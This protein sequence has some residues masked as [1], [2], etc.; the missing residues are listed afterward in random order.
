[1]PFSAFDPVDEE[2][3][4]TE[5]AENAKTV[6]TLSK[7]LTQDVATRAM[8][9]YRKAPYIPAS[10]ILSMAKAGTSDQAVDAVLPSAARKMVADLDP[11]KEPK[12]SWFERNVSGKFKTASRWTF[13][14][15]Q[16][17]PDLAQNVASQA[18][19]PNDPAGFDGWFKS[20][21]LGTMIGDSEQAGS[22]FF[23]GGEAL[24]KQA[25]RARRVRGTING[26]AWTVGRGAAQLAF[27]PGS[28]PYNVLSGFVDAAVAIG[29][30]PTAVLGKPVAA[31]R[32]GKAV[33][34]GVS[35]AAEVAAFA[36]MAVR[37]EAGLEAAEQMAFNASK[38]GTW[39]RTDK[40]AV[41]LTK[42][43]ADLAAD[44]TKTVDDKV[45]DVLEKFNYSI[46][47][48]IARR[49]A[50]ADDITKVE[51]LLG[52]AS[53]RLTNSVDEVLLPKDVRDIR[54][55]TWLEDKTERVP[56]FRSVRNNR[57]F[58]TMPK[59]TV[60]INGSGLDKAQAIRNYS[61]YLKGVGIAAGSDEYTNV[62]R[63][64]VNAY[65][66]S[67][68]GAARPAVQ[69]AFDEAFKVT[70]GKATTKLTGRNKDMV[71]QRI[72]DA[73]DAEL[74][75]V[76]S[77]TGDEIGWLDDGGFIQQ[78][79]EV[80]PQEVLDQFPPDAW[81]RL[82]H[83]GPGALNEMADEVAVLPDFRQ[84]RRY[85]GM[86]NRVTGNAPTEK[87]LQAVEAVQQEFWKP[88]T[89]ATGGYIMRNMIDA[90]TRIAMN[91]LSNAFTHPMD[92]IMWSMNKK[93]FGDIRGDKFDKVLLFSKNNF[94]EQQKEYVEALQEGIYRHL[95]DPYN[96]K[97][98]AYR[99]GNWA[100]VNRSKDAR[101]HTIGYVDNLAQLH[102]DVINGQIARFQLMG[103][104]Q[105]KITDYIVTWLN[106]PENAKV[107][108]SLERFAR[109]G[110]KVKD[111]EADNIATFALSDG[112]MNQFVTAW[113]HRLSQFKVNT[114]TKGDQ[115]LTFVVAHNR[116]PLMTTDDAGRKVVAPLERIREGDI[117]SYELLSGNGAA[118]SLV[119]LGGGQ[120]GVVVNRVDAD[121]RT[122][123][124]FT[125]EPSTEATLVVQPVAVDDAGRPLAAIDIPVMR[126]DPKYLGSSF[127]HPQLRDLIDM[128]G[129]EGK[130]AMV[131]KAAQRGQADDKVFSKLQEAR[132][133]F[134]DKFFGGLYGTL[135]QK[136]EKSPVFRQ[137]YYREIADLAD[138]LA[139]AEAQKILTNIRRAA[140][141]DEVDMTR[142]VGSKDIIKKLQDV[143]SSTSDAVGTA[144][145]LDIYAKAVSLRQTKD[146]LYNASER[147]NLEDML[148]VVI[149][150]G[151]A[152]R[153]V[154]GTYASALLEDPSRIRRAQL[155]FDGGRK[156]DPD[157][158]GQGFFYKDPVSG[159]YSF[160]FPLSGEISKLLTGIEAPMQAP[161][162]RLSIGLGLYPS[163]GPVGQ[164]AANRIIPDTPATDWI[165]RILF[166]YGRDQ[167]IS[168][169]PKWAQRMNEAVE[170]NT[171]NLQNVYGNT[172][173]ET[174]RALSA[175][176]EYDLS[177]PDEQEKLYADARQKAR[178]LTGLRALGQFFGPT[179]PSPEFKIETEAGDM[180]GSQ[181]VKEFQ[182]LQAENYDTA[183]QR[184]LEIYGNDALLYLSNKTESVAGGLEA[185]EQ[186][187]DWERNNE[188]LLKK[189]PAVAGFM[190]PGGDNFSFEVWSRQVREGKRRR[191][192]DREI[193]ALA[194]YRAASA[195][196][197]ELRNKLPVNPS[198][199]QKAWLKKWRVQLNKEYPGFPVVAEFNPGEFPAQIEQMKRMVNEGSLADNE[200]AGALKTYLQKRDE[201]LASL[202]SEG[203]TTLASNAA[204]PV[205]DWLGSIGRA[206]V[207]EV[208]E[209]GRI[210]DRL[211]S[212]EVEE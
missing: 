116:I 139:P 32:A 156:F 147:S 189:Y 7:S 136:L 160:N 211:L 155:I 83:T 123:D 99:N 26:H 169:V 33:I 50:E 66:L 5:I 195:Q 186:F 210:Y 107:K 45:L 109:N 53:S 131:V 100:D 22:G 96:A 182:K 174:L 12:Q 125:L 88:I 4:N 183:V 150:F 152:W 38:F 212:N 129:N 205:R 159:E 191:L 79:R 161:V 207:Q 200:V 62:M 57:F 55:A 105:D 87:V 13:A 81:D 58:A 84:M 142:W 157:G 90:Q 120:K 74:A 89:L 56:L 67:D 110:L 1:M 112:E 168:F 103:L 68:P 181:L 82:V 193:V 54:G 39:V 75:K 3:S 149:P 48:D 25:E 14:G 41:R 198:A 172:Y 21:Q 28:V 6:E 30:D 196:Y 148:R 204:A 145:E 64:V 203:Y 76:R 77:F 134:V 144:D 61:N 8:Q 69:E 177:N 46:S 151:S 43:I 111:P 190:A 102:T 52:Q 141:A 113:V 91:G 94:G 178:L 184:F 179:S 23:L 175:S 51:G 20:T 70:L 166:P 164:I 130:L 101:A 143:A 27:T 60:V 132:N 11:N 153:E 154:L 92:F 124:P 24:E 104:P 10:V 72:L 140:D 194:Q 165:S 2:R 128:K 167:G 63:K 185:T 80:I 98:K 199:D 71:I 115:D 19:S 97:A 59:N 34:P 31:A 206:L 108:A 137:F 17:I 197:R 42:Q 9:I 49:F 73:R 35:G 65:S 78:L 126:T 44:T 117:E 202:A 180:Y 146:L 201:A 138:Q 171:L 18:F 118:G 114:I 121:G 119:D 47:P 209:F 86:L 93:G 133:Y 162:Q 40:R 29:A 85:A 208:P 37:G 95:E 170:A 106:Q 15:L 135:T 127:G 187:G 173:I 192:T 122:L 158:D 176:G 188:S 36:K 163:V 16:L